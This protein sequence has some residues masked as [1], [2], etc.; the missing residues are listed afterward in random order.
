M[1]SAEGDLM[2]STAVLVT[3]ITSFLGFL[4]NGAVLFLVLSRGRKK[5]HYLFAGVL[6]ICAIWDLGVFLTM[7][8]NSFVNELIIY[9]YVVL[10]C[11]FFPALIYHFTCSYLNQPRK[12]STIF[13]WAYCAVAAILV[14]S[15]LL[16][17]FDGVYNYSW[18]NLF[19]PDPMLWLGT[20]S[21]L[22]F[23][24][25]F[26]LLSCWFLFRAYKR[27]ASLLTRRHIMYI[28]ISFL[29][30]AVAQTKIA[31][32]LGLDN[33]YLMPT[34]MLLSD[35]IGVLIGIA[36][37]K[38]R[39]FDITVIIKKGTIY[40]SLLA[41]IIFVF[42]C[43]EHLLSKYLGDLLGE[44][45]IYIHLISIAIVVGALMPVRTRLEHAIE[46]FFAKKKV[47]F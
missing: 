15:G 27:E 5:Y 4:I 36:I 29:V 37:I 31:V 20:A 3:S 9:G 28:L 23:W 46:A 13:V 44:Q 25:F 14:A 1:D 45:P 41:L 30:I 40:S 39:L 18:G 26:V 22:P 10:P 34:C 8:R 38:H 7:I 2:P 32:F 33:G 21:S 6:L 47:E 11:I 12:K 42:S 24:Y 35:I 17:N 19:R 43:S 16:G